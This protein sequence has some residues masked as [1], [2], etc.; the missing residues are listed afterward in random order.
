MACT[1]AESEEACL[2]LVYGRWRINVN[3]SLF[4][5]TDQY[6]KMDRVGASDYPLAPPKNTCGETQGLVRKNPAKQYRMQLQFV[7]NK[8]ANDS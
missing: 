1:D 6:W 8:L 4:R 5:S 7:A 3:G 2:S